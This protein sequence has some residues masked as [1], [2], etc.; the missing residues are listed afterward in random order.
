MGGCPARWLAGWVGGSST[1]WRGWQ[2]AF[3][4]GRKPHC[5]PRPGGERAASRASH[6]HPTPPTPPTHAHAHIGMRA[7][8]RAWPC[9]CRGPHPG[10]GTMAMLIM[11]SHLSTRARPPRFPLLLLWHWSSPCRLQVGGTIDDSQM[12]DGLV[13]DQKVCGGERWGAAAAVLC[14][15]YICID[16]REGLQCVFA[17]SC[18]RV[19][20]HGPWCVYVNI[21]ACAVGRAR[22]GMALQSM[23]WV[24]CAEGLKRAGLKAQGV[25]GG[26]AQAG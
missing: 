7:R 23:V 1:G 26:H 20:R 15:A 5:H 14:H 6:A 19:V 17:C 3:L 11:P 2:A 10:G 9:L 25:F 24:F 18:G 12:I 13:F 4:S 16:K 22:S 8:A 21:A